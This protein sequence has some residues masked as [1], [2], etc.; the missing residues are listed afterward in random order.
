[1]SSTTAAQKTAPALDGRDAPAFLAAL[2]ALRAGYVPEWLPGAR[3]AGAA[4]LQIA[5]HDLQAIARR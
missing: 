3:G 4:V 5:A 1:M 2:L